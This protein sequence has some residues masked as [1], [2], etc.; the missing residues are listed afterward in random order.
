MLPKKIINKLVSLWL[1][2]VDASPANPFHPYSE[3]VVERKNDSAFSILYEEGIR[4]TGTPSRVFRKD[5]FYNLSKAIDLVDG[6]DGHIAEAGCWRGLSSFVICS[7]L[8]EKDP[9]FLGENYHIFDSFQG[10]SAPTERDDVPSKA[11]KGRF[12]TDVAVVKKTLSDFPAV[13][14]HP[15]WIPDVFTNVTEQTYRFVHVDLDLADPTIGAIEYF[16]PRLEKGGVL[17]CDDYGSLPWL[18]T[19]KLVDEYVRKNKVRHLKL[20]T[21]QILL[22]KSF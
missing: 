6:V 15:G 9:S 10:L 3:Q 16:F 4:R 1:S 17:V 14:Y 20:S 2:R 18:G 22:F 11:S 21:G 7:T 8:K 13:F 19:K 5:R 12:A